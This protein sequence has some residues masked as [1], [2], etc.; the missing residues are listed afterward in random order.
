MK[1]NERR[2]KEKGLVNPTRGEQDKTM[3][4]RWKL[5]K[6]VLLRDEIGIGSWLEYQQEMRK[7]W[8]KQC[9]LVELFERRRYL[10][11]IKE[12]PVS[13]N[14]TQTDTA[15]DDTTKTEIEETSNSEPTERSHTDKDDDRQNVET[16]KTCSIQNLETNKCRCGETLET[17]KREGG[18]NKDTSKANNT[19]ENMELDSEIH[20][21]KLNDKEENGFE[22]D[23][24]TSRTKSQASSSN[25]SSARS[26][27]EASGKDSSASNLS[28]KSNLSMRLFTPNITP[29]KASDT[30]LRRTHALLLSE[31]DTA[32]TKTKWESQFFFH[33]K[34][35][36][37]VKHVDPVYQD[38]LTRIM[39]FEEKLRRQTESKVSKN[40]LEMRP[41][42]AE[43]ERTSETLRPVA[44]TSVVF[45][46]GM[47][48]PVNDQFAPNND[49]HLRKQNICNR[50]IQLPPLLRE[51]CM[52][53]SKI[54]LKGKKSASSSSS[55]GTA[56]SVCVKQKR[57]DPETKPFTLNLGDLQQSGAE[58]GTKN[59][60]VTVKSERQT[61]VSEKKFNFDILEK[62][63]FVRNIKRG[64]SFKEYM[65]SI[66][67]IRQRFGQE[68]AML[69]AS[70]SEAVYR[71]K[72]RRSK[73]DGVPN[74]ELSFES[75]RALWYEAQ[76]HRLARQIS[77]QKN[78]GLALG[79]KG[80]NY[81][82]VTVD[83]NRCASHTSGK[84][85]ETATKR[86]RENSGRMSRY[87][88]PRQ[89]TREVTK[90]KIETI[91][92][93]KRDS[94]QYEKESKEK[95]DEG[96]GVLDIKIG[97]TIANT[98][99]RYS[100]PGRSSSSHES[101]LGE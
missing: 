17:D 66:Q 83:R 68:R 101:G 28:N 45:T 63:A 75:V 86:T 76:R 94:A 8:K 52:E 99:L 58:R 48:Q 57:E 4:G 43:K 46:H 51:D 32:S 53:K 82:V 85:G 73:Y 5:Q 15:Q 22:K 10:D 65:K 40:V 56:R 49:K 72:K 19:D 42:R 59:D 39:R 81:M 36:I 67:E 11:A 26:R 62:Y 64:D 61:V 78:T 33:S 95:E 18:Q 16:D 41:G 1:L 70:P 55:E 69:E 90:K 84:L 27:R 31:A 92:Y 9:P 88:C 25:L 12:K 91:N 20:F 2:R 100:I 21:Q 60:S 30:S 96:Q 6:E 38:Y 24:E 7:E 77:V 14:S 93:L 71:D 79:L 97:V 29:K 35:F 54:K 80:K 98:G 87:F 47:I 44:T 3:F 23:Q 50:R 74:E 37:R 13:A 34:D 89:R